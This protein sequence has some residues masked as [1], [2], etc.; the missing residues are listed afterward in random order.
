LPHLA[1]MARRMA[2]RGEHGFS[3]IELIV[4]MAVFA[5]LAAA[6]VGFYLGYT[7][8]ARLAEA[9]AVAAAAMKT[10]KGCALQ[11]GPGNA[12]EKTDVLAKIG[13]DPAGTTGDG[14][15]TL[16]VATIAFSGDDPPAFSG[17]LTLSGVAGRD[18]DQLALAMYETPTGVV[19]RC[20]T[21]SLTPPASPTAG[22]PC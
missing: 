20:T 15:W 11:K 7:R 5:A 8:D 12:C 14:R 9:K 13:A 17:A 2:V 21:T 4:A 22:T 6:S 19:L 10:I 18:T 16:G 3:M 1:P